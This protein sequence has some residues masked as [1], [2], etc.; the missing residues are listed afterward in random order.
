MKKTLSLTVITL[1]MLSVMPVVMADGE[2]TEGG[3][4]VIIDN[5]NNPPEIYT[6]TTQRSWCPNDQTYHT[7]EKYG[8]E[9]STDV[10]IYGDCSYEVEVRGDY[11]FTGE[12]ITYYVI[13][14]DEDGEEDIEEVILQKDGIGIGS[15][16]EMEEV[17]TFSGWDVYSEAKFGID[18]WDDATMNLYKCVLTVDSAWTGPGIV[19]IKATDESAASTTTDWSDRLI[20]NPT[21]SVSLAGAIGFGTVEAGTTASSNTVYLNNVGTEGVVMDMYIASDDYFRDPANPTAICG[22]ANGIKY[23]RFSYRATKGSLDSGENDGTENGLGTT[24]TITYGDGLHCTTSSSEKQTNPDN[25]PRKNICSADPDEYTPMPSHSGYIFDMCR[26]INHL[27]EGSFLTQ[28]QSM[29]LTF[30]LDVPDVCEGSFTDGKFHFV[31]K[32]V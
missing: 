31:G 29:S 6:D 27:D 7:A 30:Q 32:V 2:D 22:D 20:M 12:T 15:C 8:E 13:V 3:V 23:D 21:L 9:S 19:T 24:E 25:C 16:S 5:P 14:E 4:I 18:S 10:N 11:L 1:L 17:P 26:I 28:G